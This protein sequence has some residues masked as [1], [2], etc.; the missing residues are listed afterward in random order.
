VPVSEITDMHHELSKRFKFRLPVHPKNLLQLI[1]PHYGY[2]G[3]FSH[4]PG[5]SWDELLEIYKHQIV[6]SFERT[7]GQDLL[8]DELSCLSFWLIEDTTRKGWLNLN[9][10]KPLMEVIT[11]HLLNHLLGFEI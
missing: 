10:L 9:E 1:H 3:C 2:L 5:Y 6:S 7:L 8:A 4:R 11:F